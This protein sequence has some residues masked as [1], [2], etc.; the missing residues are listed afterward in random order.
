MKLYR[1]AI[2]VCCA[3]LPIA[4]G[5]QENVT[6]YGRIDLGLDWT[7]PNK[8]RNSGYAVRDNASRFG[9]KGS[10]NLGHGLRALFGVEYG[11]SADASEPLSTRN[12]YVGM[13]GDFGA[14]ALGR[15]DSANPTKS[16]IYSLVT[17][18]VSFVIHDAGAP[19]IGTKV[20]NARNRTSNSIGYMTP[21]FSGFT[22]MTRYYYNGSD[23]E[24]PKTGPIKNEGDIRQFDAGLDYRN[25]PLGLGVAYASDRKTGGLLANDF[26]EKVMGVGS[27]DFG[28][29]RLSL[30]YGQDRYVETSKTRKNVDYWLVGAMLPMG[31]GKF[32]ANYMERDVQK[33]RHGVLTKLQFGYG[34]QL[35][36]RTM[37]YALLDREDPNTNVHGNNIKTLS[38]GMQHNF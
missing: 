11:F 19:A 14:V 15:L 20:L 18:N 24:V 13:A 12:S 27:Y 21:T 6:I 25:G 17:S 28:L 33:D 5:A 29:L 9:F 10:E 38:L 30:L 2:L 4:A 16:P 26:D 1:N 22:L 8:G 23:I 31:S 37:L 7:A 36:K 3:L 35:S 32:M 34:H